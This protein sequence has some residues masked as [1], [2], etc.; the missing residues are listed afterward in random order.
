MGYLAI[1]VSKTILKYISLSKGQPCLVP[2]GRTKMPGVV[3]IQFWTG[4]ILLIATAYVLASVV[5]LF[6]QHVYLQKEQTSTNTFWICTRME[7]G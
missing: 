4:K 7:T 3:G 6:V 1:F 5:S 2:Y